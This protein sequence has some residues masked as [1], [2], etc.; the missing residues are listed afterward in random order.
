MASTVDTIATLTSSH[1]NWHFSFSINARVV[2]KTDVLS[3]RKE[4]EDGIKEGKYFTVT[5]KDKSGEIEAIFFNEYA[6]KFYNTMHLN[7]KYNIKDGQIKD[8]KKR[9]GYE[10]IVTNKTEIERINIGEPVGIEKYFKKIDN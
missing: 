2:D 7:H 10:L 1:K 4:E 3:W 9:N 6:T 5:L 8:N